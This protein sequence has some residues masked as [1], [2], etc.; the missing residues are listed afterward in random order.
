M[1]FRIVLCLSAF[2]IICTPLNVES[3]NQKYSCIYCVGISSTIPQRPMIAD[4][5]N[6]KIFYSDITLSPNERY[7]IFFDSEDTKFIIIRSKAARYIEVFFID[8]NSKILGK[9]IYTTKA[10]DNYLYYRAAWSQHAK[11]L[12]FT[13]SYHDQSIGKRNLTLTCLKFDNSINAI[14]NIDLSGKIFSHTG[15][16][17]ISNQLLI[18]GRTTKS[19]D[20]KGEIDNAYLFYNIDD[21]SFKFDNIIAKCK[22]FVIGKFDRDSLAMTDLTN[23]Y[24]FINENIIKIGYYRDGLSTIYGKSNE[25]E[26]FSQVHILKKHN[27]FPYEKKILASTPLN[28]IKKYRTLFNSNNIGNFND[29]IFLNRPLK[30]NF[31]DKILEIE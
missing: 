26:Y 5:N 8:I 22:L 24:E 28:D 9:P 30:L 3:S 23:I 29:Y 6:E 19:M 18:T 12:F 17:T 27:G 10:A 7:D 13:G 11:M 14:R 20:E 31:S 2:L 25:N 1:L 15:L 21:W 4:L 16:W